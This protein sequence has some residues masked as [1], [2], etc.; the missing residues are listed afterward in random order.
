M[1]PVS[2]GPGV[3]DVALKRRQALVGAS[4][5]LALVKNFKVFCIAMFACIGGLLYGYNQGVFGGILSMPSFENCELH[6]HLS[7]PLSS[8]ADV[9]QI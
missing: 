3:Y 9:F 8:F 2:A 6:T 4:G 1:A 5:Q 7:S